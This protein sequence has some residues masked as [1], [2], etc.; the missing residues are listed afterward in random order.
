MLKYVVMKKCLLFVIVLPFLSFGQSSEE[1]KW[2][3]GLHL[4][5]P[6]GIIITRYLNYESSLDL[7]IGSSPSLTD[8]YENYYSDRF[9]D[10]Y[11]NQNTN[12]NDYQYLGHD[13]SNLT[14]QLRY[15]KHKQINDIDGLTWYY[16]IGA[17]FRQQ[18]IS[19]DYRY[20]NY[21]NIWI[22]VNDDK[23]KTY[24][25]GVDALIGLEY[26]IPNSPIAIFLD[27][28]TFV[29]IVDDPFRLWLQGGLGAKY[30]F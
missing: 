17:Q 5:D 30:C 9:Y 25:F 26:I 22:T 16:G 2:G 10:W 19:Y 28:N 7:N 15:K 24:D 12:W 13:V 4:G 29:E 11:L 27:I 23:E 21:D 3:A 14:L 6:T 20:R 8:R 18:T 1:Y